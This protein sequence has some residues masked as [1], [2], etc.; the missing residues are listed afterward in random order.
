MLLYNVAVSYIS[1]SIVYPD[2]DMKSCGPLFIQSLL[3]PLL[4]VANA[5][6]KSLPAAAF[7]I[8][9]CSFFIYINII[10]AFIND[11]ALLGLL[12]KT[13]PKLTLCTE[14]LHRLFYLFVPAGCKM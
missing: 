14:K 11:C 7:F 8:W 5:P 2:A 10:D 12:P 6:C 4:W 13:I 1:S 3:H 9:S